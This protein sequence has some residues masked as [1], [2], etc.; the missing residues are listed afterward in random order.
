MDHIKEAEKFFFQNILVYIN[1]VV[2]IDVLVHMFIRVCPLIN[3]HYR[4]QLC[5]GILRSLT[6]KLRE[7]NCTTELATLFFEFALI[8]LD[9]H[10]IEAPESAWNILDKSEFY[11]WQKLAQRFTDLVRLCVGYDT[12]DQKHYSNELDK[13]EAILRIAADKAKLYPIILKATHNEALQAVLRWSGSMQNDTEKVPWSSHVYK[14]GF[15]AF[16]LIDKQHITIDTCIQFILV[17]QQKVIVN[18]KYSNQQNTLTFIERFFTVSIS[19]TNILCIHTNPNM[20]LVFDTKFE[21]IY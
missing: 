13:L 21:Y 3:I 8:V 6:D 11:P 20:R 17:L 14:M 18:E 19:Y 2:D 10:T 9:L 16:D 5:S 7:S 1:A 15:P 12:I 4:N